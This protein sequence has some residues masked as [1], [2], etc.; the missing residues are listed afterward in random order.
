ML[1]LATYCRA[2]LARLAGRFGGFKGRGRKHIRHAG[3]VSIPVNVSA[4]EDVV[5]GW[6]PDSGEP[7]YALT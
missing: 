6:G 4:S 2:T 7:A 5:E 1:G 3:R